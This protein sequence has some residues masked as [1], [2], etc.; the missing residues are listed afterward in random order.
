MKILIEGYSFNAVYIL[1]IKYNKLDFSS[2]KEIKKMIS[3]LEIYL[4]RLYE[5]LNSL[6]SGE[7]AQKIVTDIVYACGDRITPQTIGFKIF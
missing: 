3:D 4:P 1:F 7:E 5:C 2:L 6:Q